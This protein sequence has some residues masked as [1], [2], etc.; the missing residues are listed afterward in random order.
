MECIPFITGIESSKLY[1]TKYNFCV[2]N[3]ENSRPNVCIISAPLIEM[4]GADQNLFNFINILLPIS[5]EI[6]V[7][8]SGFQMNNA[9][10]AV[11]NKHK[12][13]QKNANMW[14]RIFRYLAA[15]LTGSIDLI[16]IM[17]KCDKVIL[18]SGAQLYLLPIII[19]KISHRTTILVQQ[20]SVANYSKPVSKAKP[21]YTKWVLYL[22][23]SFLENLSNYLVDKIVVE[24]PSIVS[25]SN[26]SR[27]QDKIFIGDYTYIDTNIFKINKKFKHRKLIVGYVGQFQEV[28]G[29][30]NF[31]RAIPLVLA[32]NNNIQF[33]M[34]G[35][36]GKSNLVEDE[37][38]AAGILDRVFISERVHPNEIPKILNEMRLLVLP[39]LSEG[40]PII[41][42]QSMACGTPVLATPV[43]GI[44]D[45][46]INERTGFLTE[47]NSPECIARHIIKSL[48]FNQIDQIINAAHK[49]IENEYAYNC[50]VQ[51]WEKILN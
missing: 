30:I 51:R 22:V 18:H 21:Q 34:V 12:T 8:S 39:S 38:N 44:P 50:V 6:Y 20:G 4:K 10:V 31:A 40:L 15:Q 16:K 25:F 9:K 19:S 45:L 42:R 7:M 33:V 27:N 24:S 49:I 11:I 5:N 35:K 26:L 1:S 2:I 23:L 32:H 47:N 48:E 14:A 29:V 43:G 37:L 3:M 36:I 41:I 46:I 17:P 28:K 13:W